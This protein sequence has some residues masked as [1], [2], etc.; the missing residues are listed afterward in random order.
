[1]DNL[2]LKNNMIIATTDSFADILHELNQ[3]IRQPIGE[4]FDLR[5]VI[6]GVNYWSLRVL[7][8]G[9]YI[10]TLRALMSTAVDILCFY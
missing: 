3:N 2:V 10:L 4:D 1:M 9:V 6:S 7:E 5:C 8:T